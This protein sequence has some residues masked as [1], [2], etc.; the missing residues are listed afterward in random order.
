MTSDINIFSDPPM[1]AEIDG[2]L[3]ADSRRLTT[4]QKIAPGP[5]VL[6]LEVLFHF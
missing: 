5:G 6:G 3:R 1:Q 4:G 2:N